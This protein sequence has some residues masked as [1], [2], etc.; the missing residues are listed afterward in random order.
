MHTYSKQLFP[1][2]PKKKNPDDIV[3][4]TFIYMNKRQEQGWGSYVHLKSHFVHAWKL[5]ILY[6]LCCCCFLLSTKSAHNIHVQIKTTTCVRLNLFKKKKE[7][8]LDSCTRNTCLIFFSLAFI[9]HEKFYV[10][11]IPEAWPHIFWYSVTSQ[12]C[13]SRAMY[14]SGWPIHT[15]MISLIVTLNLTSRLWFWFIVLKRLEGQGHNQA[16][17]VLISF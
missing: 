5:T 16:V 8:I 14:V 7:I 13:P 2:N 12:N 3:V 9:R 4:L 11:R 15:L 6:W 10:L 17:T 1:I